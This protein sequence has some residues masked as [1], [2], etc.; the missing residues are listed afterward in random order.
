MSI[1]NS[2][3]VIASRPVAEDDRFDCLFLPF[4]RMP[5]FRDCL[6]GLAAD[7]DQRDICQQPPPC[8]VMAVA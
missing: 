2:A 6:N 3:P 8:H 5:G 7:V 1:F 4:P